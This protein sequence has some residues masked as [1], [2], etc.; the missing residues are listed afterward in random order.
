MTGAPRERIPGDA[1]EHT[2]TPFHTQ[3]ANFHFRR[4]S[5]FNFY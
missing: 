2:T 4:V 3:A 1:D 5:A